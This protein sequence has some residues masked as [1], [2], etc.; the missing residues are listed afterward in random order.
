M[1]NKPLHILVVDDDRNFAHTLCA[2]LQSEGY[3][4]REAYS[5]EAAREILMREPFDFVLSD[6]KMQD[7]S[8]PDLYYMVKEKF[9]NLPFILMTAYTSSEIIDDALAAGV[10]ASFQKPIDI[11]SILQY[12]AKLSQSLKGA[13][14]CEDREVCDLINHVLDNRR[15]SFTLFKDF[16]R[17]IQSRIHDYAIVFID[18]HNM[19]NCY[20]DNLKILLKRLP[21]NT[22]IIICDLKKS[23]SLE[24]IFPKNL[25]LIV[26]PREKKTSL[27]IE[28][29]IEDQYFQQARKS[30]L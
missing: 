16:D 11:K 22:I 26:L 15:F 23:A 6:V 18:A 25:N 30:I 7:Q 8:G 5:V 3:T 9:P 20:S 21:E 28:S 14:I 17:F 27:K 2:I 13:V 19:C 24:D 29:I 1:K 4:C 12:F 10:L